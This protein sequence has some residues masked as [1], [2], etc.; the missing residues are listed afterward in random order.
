MVNLV[1]IVFAI[2]LNIGLCKSDTTNDDLIGKIISLFYVNWLPVLIILIR[3]QHIT[4]SYMIKIRNFTSTKSVNENRLIGE[5]KHSLRWDSTYY[6]NPI[7]ILPKML[8]YFWVMECHCQ[9]WQRLVFIWAREW[10]TPV[11]NRNY[12]LRSF[13]TLD[14]L[15]WVFI[16]FFT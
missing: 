14:F 1:Y 7:Q 2:F 15:R 4:R 5:L 10:A 6:S 3:L 9:Q 8:L 13:H 16:W 11:K 12:P